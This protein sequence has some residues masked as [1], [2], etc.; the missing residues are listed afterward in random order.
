M[1]NL[2]FF[3]QAMFMLHRGLEMGWYHCLKVQLIIEEFLAKVLPIMEVDASLEWF[4]SNVKSV[5]ENDVQ[6]VNKALQLM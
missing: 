6:E 2:V 4:G 3:L 5:L 1:N